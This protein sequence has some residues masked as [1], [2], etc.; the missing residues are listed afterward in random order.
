[1]TQPLENVFAPCSQNN[2]EDTLFIQVSIESDVDNG[3][4][5]RTQVAKFEC[6]ACGE[7]KIVTQ[8]YNLP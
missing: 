5:T 7:E 6:I 8:T 3:N 2:N 1:M 4:G